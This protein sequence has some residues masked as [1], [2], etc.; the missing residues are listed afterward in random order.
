M[1]MALRFL[2]GALLLLTLAF[3]LTNTQ[4]GPYRISLS[5]KPGTIPVGQANLFMKVT[6]EQGKPLDGL[7]VRAL[8]KMPGMDMGER[9]QRALPVPG[10]SGTYS[11]PAA[12]AMAGAYEVT[13][14]ISGPQG[15]ATASLSVQTGQDLGAGAEKHF[16][17][18]AILPW[19]LLL[20]LAVF[21]LARVRKTGG[22]I[23]LRQL[24]N[25]T[26]LGGL[27]LL[28]VMLAL[29]IYAVNTKRRAGSMTPLEAQGM[30]M[31]T[32]APPGAL[33]VEVASVTA[34]SISD[35]IRYSGQAI[36]YTVQD[37]NPRVTGVIDWMPFYVGDRVKKGQILARLDTSQL[38]PQL[39]EKAA[40]ANQAGQSVSVAAT[41]FQA[42]LEE[43][44]QGRA[45]LSAKQ[46][47]VEEAVAMLDA[48][49]QDRETMKAELSLAQT[50]VGSAE[51]QVAAAAAEQGYREDELSRSQQ[52]FSKGALS[53]S[54]LQEAQTEAA[55]AKTGLNQ[56]QAMVAQ[57][58]AKVAAANANVRKG[59]AMVAA[60]QRRVQQ[61]RADVRA[62]QAMIRAKQSAAEAAK[63]GIA[64]EQAGVQQARA[65]YASAAA[66]KGYANLKSEVDGVVTDR[67]VGPGS[68]VN[69][70]QTV[71]R[72]AQV[73]PI[74]VQANIPAADLQ[75]VRV[76][77]SA[78]VT[79]G[80]GSKTIS[81]F[82]RSVSPALDPS[83][84]TGIAEVVL[85]NAN[86]TILP[87]QFLTVEINV[88]GAGNALIVPTE[89]VQHP[90]SLA[91]SDQPFVW[92]AEPT[93]EPGRFSVTQAP[94]RI[95][96]DDG[97]RVQVLSGL[98]EGQL[99]VTTG[100]DSLRDG[101]QVAADV[102]SNVSA[103]PVIKVSAAGFSPDSVAVEM[104][105]AATLTF[106][107]VSEQGCGKQVVFPDLGITKDLPLNQRVQVTFT[108]AKRGNLRFTCGM[109]MLKGT[110][111]VR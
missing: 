29:S 82:V 34:G 55:K 78:R 12:F 40:M 58:K 10:Q 13:I 21:V 69:P 36:G 79:L 48:A 63:Q 62:A 74:R 2:A 17:P 35:V 5:S 33:A 85:S 87:G 93:G 105:R 108:P 32:P 23:D 80:E 94:V 66:Q 25:R 14:R 39:A 92:V 47:A 24:F 56:A 73:S 68:L 81:G 109:N 97:K 100:A 90:P 16:Q 53:R 60:A 70:G 110:V 59:D 107:R 67:L 72:V 76:G 54:E 44:A 88:G 6:D 102:P 46:G 52:L 30:E 50:E 9:E 51:S 43:V 4:A 8:A 19:V 101:M 20:A 15:D 22:R 84:R 71:L 99:V 98:R 7:V 86:G 65:S 77:Q 104:G 95:G 28:A 42:A 41:E 37:V 103:G 38:D 11:A 61:A 1:K 45:E 75:K 31:N 83:S 106:V 27:L 89:A 26:T 3:A 91:G 96:D 111:V 18:L 64:K 57:A 49:R